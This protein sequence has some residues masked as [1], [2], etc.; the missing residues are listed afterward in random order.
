MRYLA[1]P[2]CPKV[3]VWTKQRHAR[4]GLMISRRTRRMHQGP[5]CNMG[6]MHRFPAF[7]YPRASP[8]LL[9]WKLRSRQ[10]SRICNAVSGKRFPP[11]SSAELLLYVSCVSAEKNLW[12][13]GM[14]TIRPSHGLLLHCINRVSETNCAD[15]I[16]CCSKVSS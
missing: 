7:V 8:H 11:S 4:R 5:H 3:W 2:P 13:V 10:P 9:P 15:K 12:T 6:R 16:S 14:Y 1:H